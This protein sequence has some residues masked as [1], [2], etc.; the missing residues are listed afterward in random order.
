MEIEKQVLIAEKSQAKYQSSCR[1]QHKG[2]AREEQRAQEGD[3]HVSIPSVNVEVRVLVQVF[4]LKLRL[5]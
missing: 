5:C 2:S 4:K 3:V 1:I